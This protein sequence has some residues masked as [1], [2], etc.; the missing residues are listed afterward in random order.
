M[1]RE[2]ASIVCEPLGSCD[3]V[4]A[5]GIEAM[6]AL[7]QWSID[8]LSPDP[9]LDLE[10]LAGARATLTFH[11]ESGGSRTTELL[12]TEAAYAG[13]YRDGHRYS[14]DL[15]APARLLTLRSGYRIFQDRTTQEIVAEI[16]RDA[17]IPE[18]AVAWRLAGRYAKRVYC[19]QYSAPCATGAAG[20][21]GESEWSFIERLLAD[22]G[23]NFWFEA[24]EQVGSLLVFG[25]TPGAHAPIDGEAVVPY[26]DPSGM[27]KSAASFFELER[28]FEVAHDRAQVLDYDIRQP[29]VL[30]DSAAGDG[31][32]EYFEYPACVPNAEAAAARAEV[33][34]GQLRRLAVHATGRSACARL[35]PGRVVRI[36]G[37]SDDAINGEYLIVGVQ[38]E[39]D[40]AS[41]NDARDRPYQNTVLLAPYEHPFRPELPRDVPRVDKLEPAVVTGP[42]GEEIHVDDLGRIKVRFPWDRSG[43]GD[44]RSSR[45][46]R[47][48]QMPMQGA[49]LLPRVGW[50]VLVA[51]VDGN[52]DLPFVLGRLYN[53]A[54]PTPYELPARRATST[55][56]SA[57]SPSDGTAHEIRLADD[58]GGMEVFIHAT[59][60][61]AV[62][63]GGGASTKVG[64]NEIHDI[65]KSSALHVQGSQSL[66]VGGDQSLT[67]GADAG[68]KVAGARSESIGGMESIGVTA[69]RIVESAGGYT[70]HVGAFYGLQCNQSNMT[71]QGAFTQTIGARMVLVAGLGTNLTVAAAHTQIVSGSRSIAAATTFA[72]ST[73]GAKKITAGAS[74]D[75]AG[76]GVI[77][78]VAGLG[79]VKVGG[80]ASLTAGGA[81]TVSAPSISLQVGGSL[82]ANGGST[83]ALSG[84]LHASGG[85]TK[86]DAGKAVK[87]SSSKVES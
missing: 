37:A 19:V 31:P 45:W 70:E 85:T 55:L 80:S 47:T 24:T 10:P 52:P 30:L 38:H 13:P 12:I 56:Q 28:V 83:L 7:P 59:K 5:A 65:G 36:E 17:G 40:L 74:T 18:D 67:V 11:D 6:S 25:D 21:I 8:V 4:R 23:I 14:L 72:D 35:Q 41:S 27:A 46:V 48:L 26:E 33:R 42:P 57:T 84:K 75:Q 58:R 71:V 64:A 34:L 73:S 81:I 3:V 2:H 78:N 86:L 29:D 22:D 82:T 79:A 54:A 1:T 20:V 43:I 16:L 61:Q 49:M 68:V 87:K 51:Y 39:V 9:A 62:L 15:S 76:G 63:V 60:D 66:S 53:G 77:T 32:L 69:S 50:E 44:D